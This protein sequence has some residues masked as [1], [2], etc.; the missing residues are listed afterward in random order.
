MVTVLDTASEF[1][2]VAESKSESNGSPRPL[3]C[4]FWTTSQSELRSGTRTPLCTRF[5]SRHVNFLAVGSKEAVSISITS[6][7]RDPSPSSLG[8]QVG[9][10]AGL[11]MRTICVLKFSLSGGL[12][13]GLCSNAPPRPRSHCSPAVI[14][15][16]QKVRWWGKDLPCLSLHQLH[17]CL[18]L[19]S[20][21]S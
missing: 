14:L 20:L 10:S 17:S 9:P 6:G 8:I 2:H 3:T 12:Q 1:S 21:P 11:S 16:R 18:L 5:L 7:T 13:G 19:H 4:V 15:C